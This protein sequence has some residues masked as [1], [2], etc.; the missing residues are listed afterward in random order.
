MMNLRPKPKSISAA[1]N[2]SFWSFITKSFGCVCLLMIHILGNIDSINNYTSY[3]ISSAQQWV[4][5]NFNKDNNGYKLFIF[6]K[7]LT[8]RNTLNS[9]LIDAK[10]ISSDDTSWQ[11]HQKIYSETHGIHKEFKQFMDKKI[12]ENKD[13]KNI[14]I[15][16]TMISRINRN[17]VEYQ[18][19]SNEKNQKINAIETKYSNN[20][21]ANGDKEKELDNVE[22]EFYEGH[23]VLLLLLPFINGKEYLKYISLVVDTDNISTQSTPINIMKQIDTPFFTHSQNYTQTV[24]TENCNNINIQLNINKTMYNGICKEL[25]LEVLGFIILFLTSNITYIEQLYESAQKL[26]PS[27]VN[28]TNHH[29]IG[30]LKKCFTKIFNNRYG[31]IESKTY[32]LSE[33]KKFKLFQ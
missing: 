18:N 30:E 29:F 26:Y 32:T 21:T 27:S 16:P 28:K 22:R 25:T 1:L 14:F 23:C 12:N 5:I 24:L 17:S 31:D 10:K 6:D 15:T 8:T 20:A 7:I 13:Q 33:L 2:Q 4:D 19:W 9:I 11:L 3:F